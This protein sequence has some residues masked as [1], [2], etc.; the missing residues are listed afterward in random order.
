MRG[1]ILNVLI[2]IEEIMSKI[3]IPAMPIRCKSCCSGRREM[4]RIHD[5]ALTNNLTK[6]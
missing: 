4:I 6:G 5:M 2:R 3:L 1:M